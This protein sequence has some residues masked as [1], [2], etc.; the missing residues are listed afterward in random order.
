M[1]IGSTRTLEQVNDSAYTEYCSVFL[2]SVTALYEDIR[3]DGRKFLG[4][5]KCHDFGPQIS[6]SLNR[7]IYLASEANIC[8]K[9]DFDYTYSL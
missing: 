6:E 9:S 7:V 2:H 8:N 3:G 4:H 1:R 5:F